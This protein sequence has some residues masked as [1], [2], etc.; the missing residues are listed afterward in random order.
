MFYQDIID[1]LNYEMNRILI[2]TIAT[3]IMEITRNQSNDDKLRIESF[4]DKI[5]LSKYQQD[6]DKNK[7]QLKNLL[8]YKN[9]HINLM[10]VKKI[11]KDQFKGEGGKGD[12]FLLTLFERSLSLTGGFRGYYEDMLSKAIKFEN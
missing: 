2:L 11:S 6:P 8:E 5:M 9:R 12:K 1:D 3:L 10:N 4:C 7:Q